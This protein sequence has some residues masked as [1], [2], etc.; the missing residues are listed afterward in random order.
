MKIFKK[1]KKDHCSNFKLLKKCGG[2][3]TNQAFEVRE[4]LKE[5][6]SSN[7]G[8]VSWQNKL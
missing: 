4:K 2:N 6:F 1:L 8:C 3:S 7:V 5:Y